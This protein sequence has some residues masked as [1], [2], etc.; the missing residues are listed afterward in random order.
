VMLKSNIA[1]RQIA[2]LIQCHWCSVFS[3]IERRAPGRAGAGA[4][5]GS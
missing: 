4:A 3:H 1:I 2:E 5:G